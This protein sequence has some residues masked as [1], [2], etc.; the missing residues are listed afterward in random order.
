[1]AIAATVLLYAGGFFVSEVWTREQPLTNAVSVA[2]VH[3]G[4]IQLSDG[5]RLRPAGVQRHTGVSAE[6]FDQALCVMTAQGLVVNRD[7]GDGRAFM[8]VEPKFYNWCGTRGYKGRPWAHWAGGY[9][10]C[11]LSELLIQSAH[12]T[13]DLHEDGLTSHELWRLEGVLHVEWIA[14]VPTK[15][16]HDLV[17]LRY[18]GTP[19]FWRT[20]ESELEVLWRPPPEVHEIPSGN[21]G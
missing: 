19:L 13:P 17:A 6:E 5:R 3:D 1:V 21:G 4:V 7:L 9:V 20:F 18:D 12:A 14:D 10:A 15:V 16:S 2:S 11:P 8:T